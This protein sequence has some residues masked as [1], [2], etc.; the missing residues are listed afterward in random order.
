M[1]KASCLNGLITA[2]GADA[3]FTD[4]ASCIA[5]SYDNSA[6]QQVPA[7]VVFATSHAEVAAVVACCYQHVLPITVRGKGSSTT[8][9]SVSVAGGI[10]LSL[11]RM[12]KIL[13]LN[14]ANR[15]IRVEAGITNLQ[16][17]TRAATQQLFWPPD[18]TSQAYSTVGGN[19][20]CNAGG[21]HTLKYGSCRENTYALKAVS[22]DGST[23][24]TGA[25]TSKSAAGYDLTR[26]LIGSEGTLAVITEATLK[27]QPAAET[28]ALLQAGFADITAASH[29]I[30]ALMQNTDIP[31][32]IELLDA[33]SLTM[34]ANYAKLALAPSVTALL[35]IEVDGSNATIASKIDHTSAALRRCG[36][37]DIKSAD[38]PA[39]IAN[40]WQIRRALSP[41][42]RHVADSKI[43][44][45]IVVP[46]DKIPI[47]MQH[48]ETL[49]AKWSLTIASFG[50]A[51]NG[52]LHVNILYNKVDTAQQQRAESCLAELMDI[53]IDLD[54]CISGEHG[55]GLTKQP[56]LTKQYNQATVNL[57]QKIKQ[58]FDP[59]N[60][61]N[62]NKV[63][64]QP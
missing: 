26:L 16:V 1:L 61:L 17:Q 49:S 19:L 18:P 14:V 40:L 48:V 39:D 28:R 21:P 60:I 24:L 25:N 35:F 43:N 46:L 27:L 64:K 4:Q 22:G 59:A 55:I 30:V 57:M 38:Q 15:T 47:L 51:G 12:N 33:T 62:P 58:Q 37:I 9:A 45:D 3:V 7:A 63:F 20:A 10:V 54:G 36:A 13:A 8:G 42:L 5:Y 32:S 6:C 53:V 29:A 50:H 23:L 52:N 2:V 34:I 41:A 11:E 31:T 44:E 56:F